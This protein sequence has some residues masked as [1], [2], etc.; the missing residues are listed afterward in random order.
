V[1]RFYD[2]YAFVSQE[3][4]LAI[5]GC[6]RPAHLERVLKFL[7]SN[8]DVVNFPIYI[9]IDYPKDFTK[10]DDHKRV[11]S[12][13]NENSHKLNI[14]EVRVQESN[15]GLASSIIQGVNYCFKYY[16]QTIILEDDILVSNFFLEY[17]KI[18]LNEFRSDTKIGS[19]SGFSILASN[20]FS[21][22]K[23]VALE[24]HSSWG[25]A[26][27]KDRW[28]L[29]DWD[30]LKNRKDEMPYFLKILEEVG[31][32]LPSMLEA[33]IAAEID[34]WAV[35][36]TLNMK[37]LNLKAVYPIETLVENI[38]LDGSGTNS[39]RN[40]LKKS[41]QFGGRELSLKNGTIKY[42]VSKYY[43]FR[44]R[45]SYSKWNPFPLSLFI[46][47]GLGTKK[48]ILHNLSRDK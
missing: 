37:L 10:L 2:L 25:W 12:I 46:M 22:V 31:P 7:S 42:K 39:K 36:F 30:I 47:L 23:L 20:K 35:I 18:C 15:L 45:F 3:I 44:I 32:D 8:C 17:M 43:D 13:V 28:E 34:S 40:S 48:Y 14:V 33:L 5:F 6:E 9:F 4:C 24:R 29:V 41:R 27:W 16:D 21:S 38:G 26:T 1:A 19:I 11:V